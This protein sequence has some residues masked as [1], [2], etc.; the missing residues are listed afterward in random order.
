MSAGRDLH[1]FRSRFLPA[2]I[3]RLL[4]ALYMGHQQGLA[5]SR[6]ALGFWQRTNRVG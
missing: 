4:L 5:E 1:P 6:V 2:R 3:L